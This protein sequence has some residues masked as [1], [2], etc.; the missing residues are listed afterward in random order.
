VVV[1]RHVGLH[2]ADRQKGVQALGTRAFGP[3]SSGF[4]PR[5]RLTLPTRITTPAQ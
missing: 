4:R 3:Q 2:E 5:T 1:G